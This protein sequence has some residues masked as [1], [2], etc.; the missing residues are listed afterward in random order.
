[1]PGRVLKYATNL[2]LPNFLYSDFVFAVVADEI[3]CLHACMW[4]GVWAE[5]ARKA[6][7]QNVKV[8]S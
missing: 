1:M 4:V 5:S 6:L 3:N 8:A 7:K 2:L